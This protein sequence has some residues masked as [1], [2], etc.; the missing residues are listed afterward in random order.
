MIQEIIAI[1]VALLGYPI[2]LLIAKYTPEELVQGRKWFM[3]IILAC[4]IAM[5]LA[6]IFTWGN[7]LLFLVSS[8]IFIILVS[9]ASLVKSMRRKKR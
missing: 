2:G 8:L 1:V 6:F 3:I 9:L 5:A 4:L 7:T